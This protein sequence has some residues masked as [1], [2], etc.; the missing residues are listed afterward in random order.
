[1]SGGVIGILAVLALALLVIVPSY[2]K[3]A[4]YG[5]RTE[6][7]LDA[8]VESNENIYAMGVQKI[9]GMAQ[10]PEM[11]RDDVSKVTKD[12]ISG[13]YGEGGSKAIFQMLKEQNPQLDPSMYTSIQKEMK[14]FY[15]QFA[16]NQNEMID[17]KR[18]YKTALGNVWQ[19]MWLGFAGYPK[20]PLSKWDIVT[21]DKAHDTFK[22]HRDSG[23]Q[24]RPA[25]KQ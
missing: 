17:Q 11:Y 8:K 25:P 3:A 24:L 10:V 15:D 14:T 6:Q 22:T 9:I 1:M 12:A 4:N 21:T 2:I 18:S 20:Q 7:A 13:R 19:G 5:N 16:E 23:M